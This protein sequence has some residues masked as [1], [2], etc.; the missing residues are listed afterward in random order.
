MRNILFNVLTFTGNTLIAANKY[1]SIFLIKAIQFLSNIGFSLI[2]FIV[3]NL[4]IFVDANR[5]ELTKT[6]YS[7]MDMYVELDVISSLM[8]IR[9]N[10]LNEKKWTQKDTE[11][12]EILGNR[13]LNE[14]NWSEKRVHVYMKS[15]VESIP[16]LQYMTDIDEY[17]DD[18]D[19][20][21]HEA[22]SIN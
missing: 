13:L 17:D 19:D 12:L 10:V 20:D 11:M 18:D 9:E 1:V 15:I 14:C 8:K 3:E 22:I 5:F 21:C 2:R 7:Q 4:L 6:Y 16:G